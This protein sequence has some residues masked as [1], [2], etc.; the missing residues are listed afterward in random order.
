VGAENLRNPFVC[1]EIVQQLPAVMESLGIEKLQD[2]IGI[3]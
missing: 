3:V 2:I 1:P